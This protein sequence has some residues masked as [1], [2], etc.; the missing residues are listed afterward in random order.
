MKLFL[1]AAFLVDISTTFALPTEFGPNFFRRRDPNVGIPLSAPVRVLED[2]SA[3]TQKG[4]KGDG[5]VGHEMLYNVDVAQQIRS[6]KLSRDH[7]DEETLNIMADAGWLPS[8]TNAI[9]PT[10]NESPA[11]CVYFSYEMLLA[12]KNEVCHSFTTSMGCVSII[13]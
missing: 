5:I 1:T 11:A 8:A 12:F 6:Y 3:Y 9:K 13:I 2:K 4:C 7:G 10:W